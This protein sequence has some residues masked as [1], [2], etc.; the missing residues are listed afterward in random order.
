[1]MLN[2]TFLILIIIL[3]IIIL[4]YNYDIKNKESFITYNTDFKKFYKDFDFQIK[5]GYLIYKNGKKIKFTKTLN[6]LESMKL[7][8]NKYKTKEIL[9]KYNLAA[10]KG[11]IFNR[12]TENIN[13]LIKNIN[14]ELEYPLVVKPTNGQNSVDVYVNISN[15]KE[16][17]KIIN[18]LEGKYKKL[19]IE[20]MIEGELYR[21]LIINNN[22]VDIIFR[23]NAYII[24]DGVNS[25]KD[26]IYIENIRR[27]KDSIMN[28]KSLILIK[29]YDIK[30]IKKQGY[31]LDD[32]P[33][34]NIKIYTSKIPTLKTGVKIKRINL[35]DVHPDNLTL[36]K[37][38]SKIFNTTITGIDFIS[39]DIS[40]SY[41]KQGNILELNSNPNY[42]F[43]KQNKNDYSIIKKIFKNL[44]N[45]F[46]KL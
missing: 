3:L 9:K 8:G 21:I 13:D 18:K 11:L 27:K 39:K 45:Y 19:I 12:E 23:G 42:T 16:L 17:I 29:K 37:K 38:V 20:E 33:P 43:H 14:L 5:D 26:L 36:F 15:E 35:N 34:K 40:K 28:N 25:I 44:Q 1:M 22:I 31:D 41:K 32:I 6:P 30:Y 46:E 2:N 4:V 24:G 10:P 7:T